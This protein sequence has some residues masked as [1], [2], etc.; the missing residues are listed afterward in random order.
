MLERMPTL[1]LGRDYSR[2]TPRLVGT[3]LGGGGG[4]MKSLDSLELHSLSGRF[5]GYELKDGYKIQRLQ[6]LTAEGLRSIRLSKSAKASIFRLNLDTPLKSGTW[7]SLQVKSKTDDD[8]KAYEIFCLDSAPTSI[9]NMDERAQASSQAEQIRIRVC[10][11]GTC[12]KRGAQQVY[13]AL[14]QEIHDLGL[15]DRVKIETTGCLK[16][17]KAG[18]NVEVNGICHHH[19]SPSQPATQ[20]PLFSAVSEAEDRSAHL[21]LSTNSQ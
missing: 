19:V 1:N 8:L 15:T 18:V 11:R 2:S 17:C 10:D 5:V 9:P 7:L 12:R 6:L 16:A 3:M 13:A 21:L 20:I 4:A 14:T